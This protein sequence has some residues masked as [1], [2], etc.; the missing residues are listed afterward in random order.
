[1]TN[2][3]VMVDICSAGMPM[4]V[5]LIVRV[6]P[7]SDAAAVIVTLPFSGVNLRAL[8]RRLRMIFLIA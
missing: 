3:S 2:G 1:M 6:C 4:P 8:A 7:A 5:S